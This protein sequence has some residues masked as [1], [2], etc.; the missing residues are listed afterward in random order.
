MI[1]KVFLQRCLRLLDYLAVL[2]QVVKE[3]RQKLKER[4]KPKQI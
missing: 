3:F 1:A 4:G 2:V